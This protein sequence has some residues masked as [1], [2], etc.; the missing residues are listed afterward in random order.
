M[1]DL[2]EMLE[3]YDEGA[4][5]FNQESTAYDLQNEL[6]GLIDGRVEGETEDK[7]SAGLQEQTREDAEA[8]MKAWDTLIEKIEEVFPQGTASD[9]VALLNEHLPREI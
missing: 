5:P 8:H 1:D 4:L 3:A 2:K 6:D 7:L 9:I